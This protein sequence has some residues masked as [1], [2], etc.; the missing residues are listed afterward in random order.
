LPPARPLL[1]LNRRD[2]AWAALT[3]VASAVLFATVLT[4]HTYLGDGP[5][6]VAGVSSLGILHD[7]G[8]PTYVL[9]AHLFTL[10]V[11]VGDEAFRVNLF[12]LVCASLT[13]GGVQLL[14]CRCGVDRWAASI[15]ALALAASAGF[16]FYSGFAK[17]DM[18]SGLLLLITLHVSLAWRARPTTG[19]L[20]A[21]AA[22]VGLGLGSSWPLELTILPAIA[23]VL[24]SS[25]RRLSVRSLASATATGLVVLIAMY[26]FVMVRAAQNPP[27]NWGGA[28]TISRLWELVNRADFTTHGSSARASSAGPP[29]GNGLSSASSLAPI[30]RHS[31]ATATITM[32]AAVANDVRDYPVI[33]GRELG[34]LAVLIAVFGLLASLTWRRSAASYP[35]LIAFLVN[36]AAAKAVVDFGGSPGGFGTDLVDEG[37]VLGCYF[38]LACWLSVGAAELI[39]IPGRAAVSGRLAGRLGRPVAAVARARFFGPVAALALGAAVVVP[40]VLGNWS[41]VHR[42]SKPFADDYAKAVFSELPPHAA[43]FIFGA[44]LTQPLIYRQIVYHQ[45][46]DAV[47]IAADGLEYGWYRQQLSRRLGIRLPSTTGSTLAD[48]AQTIRSVARVRPVYLDPQAAEDFADVL[49]YR[50]VGLLSKLASGHGPASVS[51]PS[52]VEQR[53]LDAERQAGFPDHNWTLWPNDYLSQ[54][55]YATAALH[56]AR[57]YYQH[58]DFTGMHSA[59]LN[60]L[61][62]EPGDPIAEKDLAQL[63]SSGHG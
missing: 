1:E 51:S 20:A 41:T 24:F 14:A 6:T 32:P 8:Y 37:F 52:E 60:A 55:E 50:P 28:T 26:G 54:S 61:K 7:P 42:S 27:I 57:A 47:V 38:T 40:L 13:V 30:R 33:F 4:S 18:F 34:V 3:G 59:L 11:P 29:A 43:V 36:L 63:Q 49:G 31:E 5:E 46:P 58:R 62:I 12:S 23:F 19:R 2:L 44:E 22:M 45:R 25:R 53:L 21:L 39:A 10:L 15:G 35:L 17:H 9:A 16:W 56:V 48:I